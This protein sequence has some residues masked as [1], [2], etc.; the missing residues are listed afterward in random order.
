MD[1]HRAHEVNI[2]LVRIFNTYG[3]RMHPY[4]GR[5]VSN[6]IRQAITNDAITIFGDGSQ[7]RSFCYRD[8]LVHGMI[9]MMNGPDDFIGPVNLGNPHE[10]TILQ[11]AE[12]IIKLTD[13]KSKIIK[14]PAVKTTHNSERGKKIFQP[15][16]IN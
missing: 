14:K 1:Y 11:L 5:V 8:D 12:T 16:L 3:P 4:D 9:K 6:F 15:S 10:F 7:T 2:R 13:S